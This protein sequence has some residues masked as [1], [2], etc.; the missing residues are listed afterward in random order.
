MKFFEILRESRVD[1]FKTKYGRKFDDDQ[2][3]RI[4]DNVPQKFLDWVGKNLDV[5]SFDEN[6]SKVSKN[7]SEFEKISSNLP[8]TDIN[9]YNSTQEL[10]D[11]LEDYS[12]KT[13][14]E[15]RSVPGGNVVYEDDRYFVVNPLNHESSCYYGKG[16]KWCTAASSDDQ[17]TKYNTDG[18]LFYILDK[19]LKTDDPFYKVAL[20]KKFEGDESWWDATDKSFSSG[21]ILGS[22]ELNKIRDEISNYLQNQFAEQIKIWTDKTSAK[23]ERERLERLR[24]AQRMRALEAEAQER[25]DDDEWNL[26]GNIDTEGLCAH[27]VLKWLEDTGDVDVITPIE[28]ARLSELKFKLEELEEK[29]TDFE[30]TD[31]ELEELTD[32]KESVEEEISE[33]EGKIDVYDVIPDGGFYQMYQ[34]M[35]IGAGIEDR[36]YAAGN[37]VMMQDSAENYVEGLIDDIGFEG[38]S[39][40]FAEG[41]L[42]DDLIERTAEEIYEDDVQQNPEVYLDESLRELSDRQRDDVAKYKVRI[43]NM[44]AEIDRYNEIISET[45]DEDE[46]DELESKISELE[47]YISEAESEITDIE[48]SPDG[49]FPQDLVDDKISDLVYNA[50]RDPS[51]FLQE[52]GLEWGNYV[53]KSAFI[54]GV[55]DA[56]GYGIVNGY[57]GNMDE[58]DVRGE[59]Y[60]VG[61]I[62]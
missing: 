11:A 45:E 21:W 37:S 42:D 24:E 14:R 41:F 13:R 60:Y 31:E 19:K 3:K 36:R 20:L 40:G 8:K 17:F 10:D 39:N 2:L 34:F 56:D 52:Y 30:G 55:I 49:E 16:T 50:M 54:D 44:N 33:L 48:D 47:D 61:R 15:Y 28:K 57:D 59:T 27:A 1:D 12:D 26:N 9:S 51:G 5:I 43:Q 22:N 6:L 29:E 32:E 18:K 58:L 4:I 38:F 46:I 25:R 35:V 62:D 7:L 23:K 53:D